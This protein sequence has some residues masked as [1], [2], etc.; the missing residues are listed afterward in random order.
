MNKYRIVLTH[1]AKDDIIDIG[2]YI[3]FT[4]LEPY[5]SQIFIKGLKNSI[6]H[7]KYFPFKFPLVQDEILQ[8][9]GIRCMP[10][11]NYYIFYKIFSVPQIVIVLR[12]GYNKRNW[13]DILS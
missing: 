12:I 9:Q 8:A 4:L 3:S 10:Y 6:S 1:R 11:K 5:T 7:L 13:K 2:D